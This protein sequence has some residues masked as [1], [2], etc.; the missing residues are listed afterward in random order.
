MG[1]YRDKIND[2]IEAPQKATTIAV[3]AVV[4]AVVAIIIATGAYRHG[5]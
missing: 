4:V 5:S 3:V 1:R 2:M